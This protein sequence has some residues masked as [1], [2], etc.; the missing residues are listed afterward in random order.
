MNHIFDVDGTNSR[1]TKQAINSLLDN[2]FHVVAATGRPSSICDE[3]AE[4]GIE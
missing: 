3:I 1:S 4:L 2:G